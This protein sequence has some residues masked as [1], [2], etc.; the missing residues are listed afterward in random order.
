[1][2]ECW[3]GSLK[4]LDDYC[5]ASEYAGTLLLCENGLVTDTIG[6]C[7]M[8]QPEVVEVQCW[9]QSTVANLDL[10]PSEPLQ[11]CYDSV[12][13]TEYLALECRII[14]CA[15]ATPCWDGQLPLAENY[16]KCDVVPWSSKCDFAELCWN[17]FVRSPFDCSC[18]ECNRICPLGTALVDDVCMC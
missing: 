9:D 6:E 7:E 18:P 17:G 16:C 10:C 11:L 14:S 12:F 1:M 13:L 8:A 4:S 5:P 15:D 3:D 2:Q